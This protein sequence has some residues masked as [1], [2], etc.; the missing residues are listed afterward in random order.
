MSTSVAMLEE[1]YSKISQ[2]MN[3]AERGGVEKILI[4]QNYTLKTGHAAFLEVTCDNP[5][6]SWFLERIEKC[7]SQ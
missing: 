6:G 5:K 7:I 4:K 2:R 1:F 3:A